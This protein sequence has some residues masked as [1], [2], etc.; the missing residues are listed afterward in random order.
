M[1]LLLAAF[2]GLVAVSVAVTFW[3][4]ATQNKDALVINLAGRQR[5]LTQQMTWLALA[6]PNSPELE[7]SIQRFDQT[8][9][10]L[11]DGGST[12]DAAGNSVILPPAPNPG[13]QAQLDEVLE[14]WDDF[15]SHLRP[16]EAP[17]LQAEAPL[18]LTKLDAVVSAFE[19]HAQGKVARLRYIQITFLAA[20]L[21]LLGW[22]Y[23]MIR[24]RVIQPL[25][26]LGETARRLGRGYLREP[27]PAMGD[28]EL[29]DLALAFEGMRAEL[30][31]SHDLLEIRVTRRTR[32][33][34]MAFE[35]SQEIIAQLDLEHVLNSVTERARSLM[36]AQSTS[37]CLLTPDN[38][39]LELV[40]SSEEGAGYIG[41]R[42][43]A[44]RQGLARRVVR[45]GET[46]VTDT[47]CS[48]C[49]FLREHTPGNCVA[50][51]L[52]VGEQTLGALCVVRN[53]NGPID[54]EETRALA[55]LANSAAIAIANARLVELGRRQAED[56]AALAE[57]ERLAAN[58]HDDLAQTLSFLN[59]KLE[60]TQEI[61]AVGEVAGAESELG[62]MKPA[63][64]KAY[65]QVRDALIGLV[66]PPTEDDIAEKLA[67]CVVDFRQNAGISADLTVADGASL[68][69]SP[70]VQT[71]ALYIVRE[72]LANVRQHAQASSVQIHVQRDNG[73]AQFTV[74]DNGRGF[75]PAKVEGNE[76][77][78]LTIM[79]TRAERS[80]GDL[81]VNSTCGTG[82]KITA[83]FPIDTTDGHH[84]GVTL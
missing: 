75:G 31:S 24:H 14:T 36:D 53:D 22:G 6:Q 15:R 44:A 18:I 45:T 84:S 7:T 11:R 82:T 62:R 32:E 48:N 77:L 81:V 5:M 17:A 80:G 50:A 21:L 67:A 54:A 8:L 56:M 37:L 58:L 33:L 10:A 4:I 65:R 68:T 40:S 73:A 29:G 83:R 3:G 13:L 52:S 39:Y 46:V 55:L 16:V 25:T 60:R 74:E 35:L 47:A 43:S 1:I 63:I 64:E 61:L 49:R 70:V 72:A 42:Q 34:A 30:A 26:I 20:A 41:L 19:T 57:R 28:D 69:L 38:E 79:Q 59:I 23:L 27:V 78:G 66:Q 9:H 2:A 76:H 71:Q 51:P 12:Q